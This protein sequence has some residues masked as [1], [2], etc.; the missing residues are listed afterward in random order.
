MKRLRATPVACLVAA[1]TC[2]SGSAAYAGYS[3][4]FETPPPATFVSKGLSTSGATSATFSSS[5]S[6]GI[7]RVSDPIHPNYGGATRLPA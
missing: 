1:V 6:G 3:Y 2:L 4:D 7:F 5:V